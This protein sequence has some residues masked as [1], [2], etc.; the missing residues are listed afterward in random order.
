VPT[1]AC[2]YCHEPLSTAAYAGRDVVS[3]EEMRAHFAGLL[4]NPGATPAP[5]P[6][7]VNTR[8][9]PR[10]CVHCGAALQVPLDMRAKTVACP[11]CGRTEPVARYLSDAQRL[12]L[13]A[14]QQIAGNQALARLRAEGVPCSRCG[15]RTPV[16]EQAAVQVICQYCKAPILL[17]EHVDTSAVARS[18]LRLGVDQL[19]ASIAEQERKQ[20]RLGLIITAV[21][22]T[23]VG[24]ALVVV[25]V[26]QAVH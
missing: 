11:A 14:Q 7:F 22:L 21:V 3:A 13:D 12:L 26:A 18:R 5:Q 8:T 4:A 2:A 6:V 20:K 15:A 17:S 9:E 23:C 19:R 24:L 25:L 1:F 10:P 16:T